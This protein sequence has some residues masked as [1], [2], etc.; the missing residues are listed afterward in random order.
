MASGGV[1]SLVIRSLAVAARIISGS[2]VAAQIIGVSTVAAQSVSVSMVAAQII[3]VSTVAAQS[4]SG[5]MVAA[6]SVSGSTVTARIIGVAGRK[7]TGESL[8]ADEFHRQPGRT[9]RQRAPG[10]HRRKSAVGCC[11]SNGSLGDGMA[12]F[13]GKG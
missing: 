11:G 10:V 8:T 2:T 4:V 3:G 1:S 6:Q 13:L 7:Q 5:S 12:D 9:V